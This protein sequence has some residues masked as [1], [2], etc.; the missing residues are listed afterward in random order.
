MIQL[1]EQRLS[2][3]ISA[4]ALASWAFDR[5][6]AIEEGV[7]VIAPEDE[8]VLGAVLDDLMFADEES[9]ALDDTDLRRFIARLQQ[10]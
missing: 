9:F 7:E 3:Q 5:F 4:Q 6:Y 8:D 10:L 1:I 2:G